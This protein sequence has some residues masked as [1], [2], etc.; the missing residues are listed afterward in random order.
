M[1]SLSNQRGQYGVRSQPP[2]ITRTGNAAIETKH[3]LVSHAIIGVGLVVG[4]LG[5]S[6]YTKKKPIGVI[7]LGASGSMV[8]AGIIGLLLGSPWLGVKFDLHDRRV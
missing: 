4:A 6:M 3:T 2:S 1:S 7:A 8:S 5:W